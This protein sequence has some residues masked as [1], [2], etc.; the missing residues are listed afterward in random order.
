MAACRGQMLLHATAVYM[1]LYER[2]PVRCECL[3][4]IYAHSL[5]FTVLS[6]QCN[7]FPKGSCL[8]CQDVSLAGCSDDTLCSLLFGYLCHCFHS[9]CCSLV[10]VHDI[11]RVDL[12]AP[13]GSM[14]PRGPLLQL[15]FCCMHHRLQEIVPSKHK[16][17]ATLSLVNPICESSQCRRKARHQCLSHRTT[18]V[19]AVVSTCVKTWCQNLSKPGVKTW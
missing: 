19:M 8:E 4:C 12:M 2:I 10:I 14:Q 15:S 3:R 17:S 6:G 1:R 18:P 13:M 7:I 11:R 9:A 16:A 5:I